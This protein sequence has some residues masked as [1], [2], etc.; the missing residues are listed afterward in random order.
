MI[1]AVATSIRPTPPASMPSGC[2][3]PTATTTSSCPRSFPRSRSARSCARATTNGSR[4]CARVGED[5]IGVAAAW[6]EKDKCHWGRF[7]VDKRLRGI[8]IGQKIAIFSLKEIFSFND[9]EIYIEARD[10]TVNMLMKFGCKVIGESE[11]FYN[12]PVTP[13]I[14]NKSNFMVSFN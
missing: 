13:I 10:V 12:E 14:L 3:S 7:A 2:G 9:E 1:P 11:D 6:K 5:I 8:G 4:W